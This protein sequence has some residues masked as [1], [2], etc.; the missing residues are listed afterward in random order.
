MANITKGSGNVFEDCGFPPEE[1]ADLK[2]RTDLMRKLRNFIRT[3]NWTPDRAASYFGES[4][5]RIS[6]LMDI[7]IEHFTVEQ[8]VHLLSIAGIDA[9]TFIETANSELA[10][11]HPEFELGMKAYEKVATKYA[12]ALQELAE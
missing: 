7:D 12:D 5:S 3:H 10:S 9:H 2:L 1:A 4:Q 8:L 11:S 6:H